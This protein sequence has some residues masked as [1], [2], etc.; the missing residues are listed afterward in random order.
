MQIG[1][2]QPA[3]R[4]YRELDR[5]FDNTPMGMENAR[6]GGLRK[7]AAACGLNGTVKEDEIMDARGYNNHRHPILLFFEQIP[8]NSATDSGVI[9]PPHTNPPSSAT[10]LY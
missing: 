1:I 2:F 7:N 9:R 6:T 3:R 5:L 4:T 10:R 8:V